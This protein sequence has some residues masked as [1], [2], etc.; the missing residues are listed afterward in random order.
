MSYWLMGAPIH[1]TEIHSNYVGQPW[2]YQKVQPDARLRE[3]D[4]IYLS[5][6]YGGLYSWGFVTK[7]E[8][9]YDQDMQANALRVSVTR[10]VIR[11]GLVPDEAVRRMPLLA[12]LFAT[13][14]TNLVR[15]DARQVAAFNQ[16]LRS[17]AGDAPPD[18]PEEEVSVDRD[19][20]RRVEEEFSFVLDQPVKL[21]E[22]RHVEFKEVTGGN[23]GSSI[24]SNAD[25]Y[26]VAFLN[27]EGGRI[28][29]GIRD[30]DR[31]VVGVR[32]SY[33]QRDDIRREVSAKL[34]HIQPPV[35]PA[36][37]RLNIH[38]V[39]DGEGREVPDL[40]VVELVAPRGN[41]GKLYATGSD[42][43]WVKTDGGKRKLNHTQKVAEIERRLGRP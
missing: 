30:A 22:M 2:P 36:D 28:F 29:W 40:Y 33:T 41:T 5:G 34:S 10:P 13:R 21:E 42:D 12:E 4:V 7:K 43:V 37:F 19:H 38:P 9:Y 25:E 15:L 20:T 35:P 3:G 32:L 18:M 27:C 8:P 11:E 16:L 31:I 17:H 26:A 14:K 6:A 23:P 39:R 1:G 24:R